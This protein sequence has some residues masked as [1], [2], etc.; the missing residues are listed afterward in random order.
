MSTEVISVF[1]FVVILVTGIVIGVS[2]ISM[3]THSQ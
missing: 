2:Y 3:F 1:P